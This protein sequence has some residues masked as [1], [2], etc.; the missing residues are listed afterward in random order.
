MKSGTVE[1]KSKSESLRQARARPLDCE[2]RGTKKKELRKGDSGKK[3]V[4]IDQE[5][6]EE[7]S[8]GSRTQRKKRKKTQILKS[9]D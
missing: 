8:L 5:A 7:E 4:A 2:G 6:H 9:R 1:T 3:E